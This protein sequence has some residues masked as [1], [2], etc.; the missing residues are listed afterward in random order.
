MRRKYTAPELD[1]MENVIRKAIGGGFPAR[2][3]GA[4]LRLLDSEGE[5]Y[6]HMVRETWGSYDLIYRKDFAK[7]LW[8]EELQH[9]Q[10]LFTPYSTFNGE[11]T[12]HDVQ[13][14]DL[15]SIPN[16]QHHLQQMVIADDPIKYLQESL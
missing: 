4:W 16:W 3:T 5:V 7:A 6:G 8:G 1:V 15:W 13:V 2:I 14:D 12:E 10:G 11:V 9:L